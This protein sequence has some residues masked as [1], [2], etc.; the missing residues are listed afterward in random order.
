MAREQRRRL[1]INASLDEASPGSARCSTQGVLGIAC[2]H[3]GH[4]AEGCG[5]A[6][7][8]WQAG[9]SPHVGGQTHLTWIT[10]VVIS[11]HRALAYLALA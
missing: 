5:R 8:G 4:L 1:Q 9:C 7:S 2:I 3:A 6:D 10:G 11:T